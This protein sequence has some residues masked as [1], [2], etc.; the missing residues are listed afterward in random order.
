MS[1]DKSTMSP[2]DRRAIR[3]AAAAGSAGS[4]QSRNV[5]V[6]GMNGA[7][8]RQGRSLAR[9]LSA[10]RTRPLRPLQCMCA[11]ALLNS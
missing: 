2:S 7:R 5:L 1:F 10:G 3:Y 9:D 8:H 4:D 11:A 6:I